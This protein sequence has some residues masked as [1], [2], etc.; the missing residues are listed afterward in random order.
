MPNGAGALVTFARVRIVLRFADG[1]V[2]LDTIVNFPA[3]ASELPVGLNIPLPASAP[4]GGV[5]LSMTLKYVNAA[6]DTVF[7]GGPVTV[8]AVPATPGA[9]PPPPSPVN[10]PLNYTGP[11]AATAT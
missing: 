2:A 11:G 9:A 6:G 8:T 3:G 4:S 7:S 1:A 5:P 10:V